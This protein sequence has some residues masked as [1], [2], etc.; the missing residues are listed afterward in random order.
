MVGLS[1]LV[2]QDGRC[3]RLV[4]LVLGHLL[5]VLPHRNCAACGRIEVLSHLCTTIVV[6][7]LLVVRGSSV[8]AGFGTGVRGCVYV[9][10]R[11]AD[12]M[13]CIGGIL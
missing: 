5:V 6:L 3:C 8:V 1:S 9:L 2:D 7:V 10:S 12:P 11:S 13:T 4:V